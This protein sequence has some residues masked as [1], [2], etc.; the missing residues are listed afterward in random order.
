MARNL[1]SRLAALEGQQK[2]KSAIDPIGIDGRFH[3]LWKR[4]WTAW[5]CGALP[6][7]HAPTNTPPVVRRELIHRLHYLA[8]CPLINRWGQYP[9]IMCWFNDDG[10]FKEDDSCH[11]EGTPVF[12]AWRDSI[13][14]PAP[15]EYGRNREG[16]EQPLGFVPSP[17]G[18][19]LEELPW[20]ELGEPEPDDDDKDGPPPLHQRVP[21]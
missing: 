3:G 21:G 17:E 1:E 9:S 5:R 2:A 20:W 6:F 13:G 7:G 4:I 15:P 8:H 14:N 10:T 18:T 19:T 12:L 11:F 16:H